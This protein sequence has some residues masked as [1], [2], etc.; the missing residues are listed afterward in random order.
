M[1]PD[2]IAALAASLRAW[3]DARRGRAG[4]LSGEERER[5]LYRVRRASHALADLVAIARDLA[6]WPEYPHG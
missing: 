3:I 4:G 2:G 1:T 5:E 6:T